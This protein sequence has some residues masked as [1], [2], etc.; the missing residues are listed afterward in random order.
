MTHQN[1]Q[2]TTVKISKKSPISK[3]PILTETTR[4]V[5]FWNAIDNPI[6]NEN[7]EFF[8]YIPYISCKK[9]IYN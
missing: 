8:E 1:Q 2:D 4:Y 7:I 3:Q 6:K 5:N 9:K